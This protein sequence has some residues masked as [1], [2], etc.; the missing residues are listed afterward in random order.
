LEPQG[1]DPPEG[2]ALSD[3]IAVQLELHDL[4]AACRGFAAEDA[5]TMLSLIVGSIAAVYTQIGCIAGY[6]KTLVLDNRTAYH[7]HFEFLRLETGF[8]QLSGGFTDSGGGSPTK[9]NGLIFMR[10]THIDLGAQDLNGIQR[11]KSFFQN[12]WK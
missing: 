1:I 8:E 12:S 7:G 5:R 11:P 3:A 6:L 9:R 10:W 4:S 2:L